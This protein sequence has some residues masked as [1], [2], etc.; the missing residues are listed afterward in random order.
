MG[1]VSMNLKLSSSYTLLRRGPG[2]GLAVVEVSEEY[3]V[4]SIV[5]MCVAIP[6]REALG[7]I[8]NLLETQQLHDPQ[9]LRL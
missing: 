3:S 5:Y 4:L 6:E 8:Q 1:V 2:G 7:R 9:A